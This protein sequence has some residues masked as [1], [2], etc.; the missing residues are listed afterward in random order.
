MKLAVAL[1]ADYCCVKRTATEQNC[2]PRPHNSEAHRCP[3]KMFSC[4]G[5]MLKVRTDCS[6]LGSC[7]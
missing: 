4:V 1:L 7:S 2:P 6:A 5:I 3:Y